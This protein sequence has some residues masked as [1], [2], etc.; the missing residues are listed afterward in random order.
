MKWKGNENALQ[1]Q[2]VE[3]TVTV[4]SVMTLNPCSSLCQSF[5]YIRP[6]FLFLYQLLE[7]Q[8]D[9]HRRSLAAL[10][11]AIPT[12][13]IQQGEQRHVTHALITFRKHDR[14]V[15]SFSPTLNPNITLKLVAEWLA[16]EVNQPMIAAFYEFCSL[17]SSAVGKDFANYLLELSHVSM[18]ESFYFP[19]ESEQHELAAPCIAM[20][21]ATFKALSLI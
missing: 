7:A 15:P 6:V 5:M 10:E 11:A 8:A 1:V 18:T 3:Y 4:S 2:P 20:S 21:N 16:N 14:C 17:F 13:Q 12:I 9:Y 19:S